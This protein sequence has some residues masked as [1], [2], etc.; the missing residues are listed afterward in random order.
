MLN[1]VPFNGA[2]YLDVPQLLGH[3]LPYTWIWGGRGT[4]KTYGFL[5]DVRYTDPRRFLLLR[6]T[7]TQIDL[8]SKPAFNPFKPI[9]AAHGS[10]TLCKMDHKVGIF[11][12]AVIEDR[13]P[14]PAGPPAGYAV[15]LSTIHNVRGID[16]SDVDI[17]IYDEYIPEPHERPIK[18]EYLAFLNAMET[19]GRNRELQGRPPLQFIG[20]SNAN[21]LGNP[22]FLG[23]RVIRVVDRMLST[24]RQIWTDPDRGLM[25][26]NITA[27]PISQAKAETSLYK[28]AGQGEY[29]E[30]SLG[31]EFSQDVCSRQG[32]IPLA[33]LRPLV[34]V[35]ELTLYKHKRDRDLLYCCDHRSGTP[36]VYMADETSLKRFRRDY[37]DIH[38]AYMDNDIVFMDIL[39]EI[40]LKKYC[41]I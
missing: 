31:N 22:Y 3:V 38:A 21:S 4:G 15:A 32:T 28:L 10:E 12:N 36:P 37:W 26:V 34:T 24:G 17:V 13:K 25:L 1:S 29:A 40:L 16:L 27:S 30:M 5:E 2:G 14:V 33:E 7:Q 39:C 9:D 19:I 6:R 35:G 18:D 41:A 20:L 11:Y 23:M 8:L